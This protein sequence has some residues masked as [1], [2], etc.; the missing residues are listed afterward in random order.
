MDYNMLNLFNKTAHGLTNIVIA[1]DQF[2]P[3]FTQSIFEHNGTHIY[4]VL[5]W[6]WRPSTM[7]GA[8]VNFL[9]FRVTTSE[10]WTFQLV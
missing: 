8:C 1:W 6:N 9:E 5:E 7:V 4:C 2:K 10:K 3:V